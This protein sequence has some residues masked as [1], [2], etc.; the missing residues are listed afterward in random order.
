MSPHML[1]AYIPICG[2]FGVAWT[3]R[4]PPLILMQSI[5]NNQKA[6]TMCPNNHD[7]GSVA[8]K[9]QTGSFRWKNAKR[10]CLHTMRDICSQLQQTNN[11]MNDISES[12]LS[13]N[14]MIFSSNPFSST[15]SVAN[16]AGAV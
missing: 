8:V 2:E 15:L 5:I 6:P 1:P 9:N 11:Y 10:D 12:N 4:S 16:P 7:N 13:E 3:T 14:K